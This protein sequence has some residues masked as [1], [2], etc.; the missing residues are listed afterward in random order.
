M[1]ASLRTVSDSL[2]CL[3]STPLTPTS[4]IVVRESQYDRELFLSALRL[5]SNPPLG[6]VI[7]LRD[8]KNI[9]NVEELVLQRN[10]TCISHKSTT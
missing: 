5:D 6:V 8:M 2:N 4:R 9:T 10:R 7:L 3:G 1:V